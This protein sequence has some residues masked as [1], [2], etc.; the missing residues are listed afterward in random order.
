M[1]KILEKEWVKQFIKFGLIGG[2]NTVVSYIA[3]VITIFLVDNIFL[4]NLMSY[5]WGTINSYIWNNLWVFKKKEDEKRNP[6]LVLGKLFIMYAGTGIV[7]NYFLLLLWID[8][9]GI[10][11]LIAPIL[12]SAFGIP[13]NF[14]V[15][16]FW[17]FK[18]IK[19]EEG[20]E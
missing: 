11:K 8:V 1:K 19:K 10:P 5:V 4:A 13:I 12:N 3:Y 7:L 15:S 20:M 9:L 14:L 2:S 18:D 16:K 17:C 6:W